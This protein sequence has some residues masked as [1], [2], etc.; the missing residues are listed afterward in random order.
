MFWY[1]GAKKG[2]HIM[3]TNNLSLKS[4]VLT[5]KDLGLPIGRSP[6]PRLV[7][8]LLMCIGLLGV[9]AVC[10]KCNRRVFQ[11]ISYVAVIGKS[12]EQSTVTGKIMG[13][14]RPTGRGFEECCVS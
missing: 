2:T 13:H 4:H 10:T 3:T 8:L 14:N 7:L 11:Y 5:E 6:K 9:T 12:R 1:V